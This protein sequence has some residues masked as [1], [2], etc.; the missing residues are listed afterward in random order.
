MLSERKHARSL[1]SILMPTPEGKIL[2]KG[3]RIVKQEEE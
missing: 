2:L 1:A 3:I